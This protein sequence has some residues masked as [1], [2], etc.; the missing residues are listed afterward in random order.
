[1]GEIKDLQ[2]I[3]ADFSKERDWE[4]Y[5]TPK[6][7]ALA[8]GSEVG[9][10]LAE[11]RWKSDEELNNLDEESLKKIS[12]ELA[13]STIF[14]LRLAEVM[15][16]DIPTSVIEKMKINSERDLKGPNFRKLDY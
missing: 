4:K 7:L 8:L 13:D 6:N 11:F 14:L 16:I 9:E 5:H 12:L 15:N 10:L 1:M 2:K 3:I